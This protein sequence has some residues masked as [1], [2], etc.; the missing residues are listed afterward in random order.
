M[1]TTD[2]VSPGDAGT[3]AAG[4]ASDNA[5]RKLLVVG[6][7]ALAA[8]GRETADV[9]LAVPSVSALPT[10]AEAVCGADG[11]AV[12][13]PTVAAQTDG[14][15]VRVVNTTA[16]EA[17]LV[18]E[19]GPQGA[20]GGHNL[21][22]IGTTLVLAVAPGSFSLG[23]GPLRAGRPAPDA[24]VE[25]LDPEGL[26]V[27]NQPYCEQYS[28]ST[29][30][31]DPAM[32]GEPDPL[33]AAGDRL[34]AI[35]GD[36]D[37]RPVGYPEG[38]EHR[39]GLFRDGELIATATLVAAAGDT[40]FAS[41]DVRCSEPPL[42]PAPTVT[43]VAGGVLTCGWEGATTN[44]A[45]LTAEPFGVQFT[46]RNA[47]DRAVVVQWTAAAGR[48]ASLDLAVGDE[49]PIALAIPPGT[50]ELACWADGGQVGGGAAL[51]VV[52]P[53]AHYRTT[54]LLCNPQRAGSTDRDLSL[55]G[56]EDPVAVA[57]EGL[58]AFG[59]EVAALERVGYPQGEPPQYGGFRDGRLAAVITLVPGQG[60]GWF[61]DSFVACDVGAP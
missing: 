56:V 16:E 31:I 7:L 30:E 36:G 39:Y 37:V 25:V 51:T 47:L 53:R 42:Q 27:V 38:D 23:C 54:E 34:H 48:G 33:V 46:V 49:Y 22:A 21:P 4:E 44:F 26:F 35:A 60:Y 29:A 45:Q 12:R 9:V 19:E 50:A 10:V 15:H 3:A 13:T 11:L 59:V 57:G 24:T 20:G 43:A 5:M 2:G 55:P 1:W 52:D 14:V 58:Q 32:R 40:W 61:A 8:C 28:G 17:A 18:Y 6:L 41:E